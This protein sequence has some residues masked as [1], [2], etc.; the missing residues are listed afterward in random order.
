MKG[1]GSDWDLRQLNNKLEM[2]EAQENFEQAAE[3]LE[4]AKKELEEALGI[5]WVE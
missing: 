4:R 5:R 2:D 3:E 1:L